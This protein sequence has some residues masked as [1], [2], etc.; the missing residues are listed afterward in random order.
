M[1]SSNSLS[2]H[3]ED[4]RSR[5]PQS[6]P[7]ENVYNGYSTPTRYS[8]SFL[9]ANPHAGH[10]DARASV[11]RRMTADAN[12]FNTFSSMTQQTSLGM[13]GVDMSASVWPFTFSTG[14]EADLGLRID[15]LQSPS[16]TSRHQ[17]CGMLHSGRSKD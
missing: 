1:A 2:S 12:L 13:D 9:N 17:Y 6:P 4:L 11:T 10:G 3:L 5:N 7:S 14:A 8:G 16:G 15:A